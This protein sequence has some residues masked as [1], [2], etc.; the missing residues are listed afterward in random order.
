MSPSVHATAKLKQDELSFT[1]NLFLTYGDVLA[2]HS[3]IFSMTTVVNSK[4][5]SSA[6]K[7]SWLSP[8]TVQLVQNDGTSSTPIHANRG[9]TIEGYST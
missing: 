7:E 5:V 6:D 8:G 4:G 3:S 2:S 9:W 1:Y